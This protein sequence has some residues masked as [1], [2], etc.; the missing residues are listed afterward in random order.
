M[1]LGQAY[2]RF[3]STRGGQQV[4]RSALSALRLAGLLRACRLPLDCLSLPHEA[5]R[6]L[7]QLWQRMHWSSHSGNL[8]MMPPS[9]QA[10]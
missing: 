5:V 6:G 8:H 9:K 1:S 2:Y 7:M 4:A 10:P 3:C